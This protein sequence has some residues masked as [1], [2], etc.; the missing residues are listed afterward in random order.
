MARGKASAHFAA[1]LLG[2][3]AAASGQGICPPAFKGSIEKLSVPFKDTGKIS[4]EAGKAKSYDSPRCRIP[5]QEY[6]GGEAVYEVRLNPGNEVSFFL[7]V[8]DGADLML[9]LVSVCGDGTSCYSNSADF[10]G[11]DDEEIPAA[12]YPPGIYYLYIDSA[13]DAPGGPYELTVRGVNPTPDLLLEVDAPRGAFAGNSVTYNLSL[14]NRGGLAADNVEI[15]HT[16]PQGMALGAS[17]DCSGGRVTFQIKRLEIE[18]SETEAETKTEKRQVVARICPGTRGALTA[19]TEAKA[20]QGSPAL[21]VPATIQVSGQSDLSLHMASSADTVVAGEQLTYTFTIHNAGPSDATEV[22]VDDT[23]AGKETFSSASDWQCSGTA[24]VSCGPLEIPAGGTVRHSI[25]MDTL[26]SALEPLVN[27]A[28]VRAEEVEPGCK[29]RRTCGPNSA[30][31]E[32]SVAR[33]T[34]LT[35]SLSQEPSGEVAVGD[36]FSYILK[37]ENEGPSDSSGATVTHC[38]P[39]EL[40]YVSKDSQCSPGEDDSCAGVLVTCGIGPIASRGRDSVTIGVKTDP[41][42]LP[43][44][45]FNKADLRANEEDPTGTDESKTV[46]TVLKI[47]ADLRLLSKEAAAEVCAGENLVYTITATNDGP[48][49]SRGGTI[50]DSLPVGLCFEWSP[51]GCITTD[52]ERRNVTCTVPPL[53]VEDEHSVRFVASL[54]G[55]KTEIVNKASVEGEDDPSPKDEIE[56]DPTRIL[57]DLAVTLSTDKD[58]VIAQEPL[59]YRVGVT[60]LGPS[61]AT[62]VKV[63]LTL[64][65][66]Q[67]DDPRC[68]LQQEPPVTNCILDFPDIEKGGTA[69]LDLVVAAPANRGNVMAAVSLVN[70]DRC[71]QTDNNTDAV[72]TTVAEATDVDLALT[73]TADAQAVAVGDLLTYTIKVV[74]Q[75]PVTTPL[76][77]IMVVDELLG[78]AQFESVAPLL[79]P[80]ACSEPDQ[81]RKVTCNLFLVDDTYPSIVVAV[82]VVE[83]TPPAVRAPLTNTATVTAAAAPPAAAPIDPDPDDNEVT[84]ETPVLPGSLL[85]PFFE[86]DGRPEEVTTLFAVRNLTSGTVNVRY[87]FRDAPLSLDPHE[88][89]IVNLRDET[90]FAGKTGYVAI[91]PGPP[92]LAGDF[93]RIDPSEGTASGELLVPATELCREWSVRFLNGEPAG[94]STEI[95]FFVPGNGTKEIIGRVYTE[96][97]KFLQR[98]TF[99]A[100][101]EVFK[102]TAQDLRLLA[103]SGS[104]EWTFPQGI[105]GNVTTIHKRGDKDEVAVPGF[106]RTPQGEGRSSLILPYFQVGTDP[107]GATTYVAIRNE[108]DKQLQIRTQYFSSAGENP[109]NQPQDRSLAGHATHTVDLRSAGLSE[110]FVKVDVVSTDNPAPLLSR[111]LSGDYIF[112]DENG[113]LAGSAL[114][115]TD[116][117][118]A[119]NQLCQI[120]DVRFIQGPQGSST[121]LLFYVP[122]GGIPEGKPY[123]EDGN[124]L[125]SVKVPVDREHLTSYLVPVSSLIPPP[126]GSG[127]IEWDL[128]TGKCGHVAM[129]FTGRGPGGKSYSV[130]IPGACREPCL[131]GQED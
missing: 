91:S 85:L 18:E 98:I 84:I 64:Q 44:T 9:A 69:G 15:V 52:F 2:M 123:Q 73:M 79:P 8:Q 130:L 34:D 17:S 81:N 122:G 20:A 53:E 78:S 102:K 131:P 42:L 90:G 88:T 51:D 106:C 23:L 71:N 22:M 11:P 97:G 121:S 45:L 127:S 66:T 31:I 128:G 104:I 43:T 89:D 108:T 99:E 60:N 6:D 50:F 109:D 96:E 82:R 54:C 24:T 101:Q 67:P 75:G 12:K 27:R 3:A 77:S 41:G 30:F 19:T 37:V 126:T 40:E 112:V 47:K 113:G 63:R 5:K 105:V 124:P 16:L 7:D 70:P 57:R 55:T 72:T 28:T 29:R 86:V 62:G 111:A 83:P 110:G 58:L 14:T 25:T 36:D 80:S 129:L 61:E 33:V 115:D 21:P 125:D 39:V 26:S 118:R 10:I 1:L 119:P 87:D 76:P 48:S 74:N 116:L 93:F 92:S 95:L 120:W 32:T 117:N 35:I 59:T 46:E 114:V 13:K 107:S 100:P 94:S 49:D 56:S 65:G 4:K 68:T 103:G 38:L